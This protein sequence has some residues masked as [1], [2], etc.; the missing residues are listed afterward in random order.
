M[1]IKLTIDA[2][3]AVHV[4]TDHIKYFRPNMLQVAQCNSVVGVG[5]EIIGVQETCEEIRE[6]IADTVKSVGVG[7][8]ISNPKPIQRTDTVC[9]TCNTYVRGAHYCPGPKAHT[10]GLGL[11]FGQ[12]AKELKSE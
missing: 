6:L 8:P 7:V 11:L 1:F 5:G 2:K 12:Y 9:P 4:N 3:T 10:A